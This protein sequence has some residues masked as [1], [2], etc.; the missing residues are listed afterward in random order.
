M[1]HFKFFGPLRRP[2]GQNSG[3]SR[4]FGK[5]SYHVQPIESSSYENE[6]LKIS[7]FRNTIHYEKSP[8][9]A[10]KRTLVDMMKQVLPSTYYLT[11][12]NQ[13][14]FQILKFRFHE[15]FFCNFSR[16][17]GKNELK[18]FLYTAHQQC[19]RVDCWLL[20]AEDVWFFC[21]LYLKFIPP[22]NIWNDLRLF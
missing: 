16:M 3:E 14:Q 15:F 22:I 7:S 8:E 11:V 10:L 13:N 19:N 6:A 17:L 12:S 9:D 2:Q 5:S 21:D 18:V 1:F 4:V 20:T